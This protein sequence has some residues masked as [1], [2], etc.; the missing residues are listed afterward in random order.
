MAVNTSFGNT[1]VCSLCSRLP[2]IRYPT[3]PKHHHIGGG[4]A[5]AQLIWTLPR[6][7]LKIAGIP[8]RIVGARNVGNVTGNLRYT[9][10]SLLVHFT[11]MWEFF[12]WKIVSVCP[13][14]W[15]KS[16]REK[17]EKL[18]QTIWRQSIMPSHHVVRFHLNGQLNRPRYPVA[19]Y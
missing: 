16:E 19:V 6:K 4:S 11:F 9:C 18:T 15:P 5:L 17:K 12:R 13:G 3:N 14:K 2:T 10:K 7:S 1:P 8:T